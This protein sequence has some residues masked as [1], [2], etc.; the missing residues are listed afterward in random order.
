MG[1]LSSGVAEDGDVFL[2]GNHVTREIAH[3]CAI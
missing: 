3:G 2:P 1:L